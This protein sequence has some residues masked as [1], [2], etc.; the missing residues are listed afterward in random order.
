MTMY[1]TCSAFGV[2]FVAM[3]IKETSGKSLHTIYK[4][5]DEQRD[6]WVECCHELKTHVFYYDLRYL[7]ILRVFWQKHSDIQLSSGVDD[8]N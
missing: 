4:E 1:A 3:V 2:I 5:N 8:D 6:C 7:C